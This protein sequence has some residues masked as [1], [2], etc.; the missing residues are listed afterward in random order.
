MKDESR[1]RAPLVRSPFIL[2]PS[3]FILSDYLWFGLDF[4]PFAVDT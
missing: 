1:S 3:A 4:W 2:H